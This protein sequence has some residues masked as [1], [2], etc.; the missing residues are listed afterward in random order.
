MVRAPRNVQLSAGPWPDLVQGGRARLAG[1]KKQPRIK[2]NPSK[3]D[4][5]AIKATDRI[6]TAHRAGD[7]SRVERLR[8]LV[9]ELVVQPP[10]T[11]TTQSLR[12][13]LRLEMGWCGMTTP[14]GEPCRF[15]GVP[16]VLQRHRSD[17]QLH[18]SFSSRK[19][20]THSDGVYVPHLDNQDRDATPATGAKIGSERALGGQDLNNTERPAAES[21]TPTQQLIELTGNITGSG[22]RSE[23][24][25][26]IDAK[27]DGQSPA[28]A[29]RS[30]EFSRVTEAAS[31]AAVGR[32]TIVDFQVIEPAMLNQSNETNPVEIHVTLRNF[33]VSTI[34]HEHTADGLTA[35]FHGRIA[36]IQ[37]IDASVEVDDIQI[38]SSSLLVEPVFRVH[39]TNAAPQDYRFYMLVSHIQKLLR[40]GNG[41]DA[42]SVAEYE[43]LPDPKLALEKKHGW[44]VQSTCRMCVRCRRMSHVNNAAAATE[45]VYVSK[46]TAILLCRRHAAEQRAESAHRR[47]RQRR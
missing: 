34:S 8:P 14:E 30:S 35:Y 7:I 45:H 18:E 32:T 3:R 12:E 13:K 33:S 37:S 17:R 6:L 19:R 43:I 38:N 21:I 44:Y 27:S 11:P 40:R 29:P 46:R 1:P 10:D 47:K 5:L 16:E 4:R 20:R 26:K 25:R 31:L 23:F 9:E 42:A 39:L 15:G 24:S 28:A 41:N 36:R 2:T 22:N